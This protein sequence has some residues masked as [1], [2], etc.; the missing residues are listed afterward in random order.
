MNRAVLT[1]QVDGKLDEI[2]DWRM[3]DQDIRKLSI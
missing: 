3:L 1:E 2:A